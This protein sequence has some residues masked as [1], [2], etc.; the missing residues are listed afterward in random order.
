VQVSWSGRDSFYANS[1]W[2]P[3]AAGMLSVSWCVNG[4]LL[5]PGKCHANK[6]VIYNKF[7]I[8]MCDLTTCTWQD[9]P[10]IIPSLSRSRSDSQ[11]TKEISMPGLA[12]CT[13]E[14][15]FDA[16]P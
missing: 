10:S 4:K 2:N 16:V 5:I 3:V 13:F 6:Q 11:T 9:L 1:I 7:P 15:K 14:I 8:S 12:Q